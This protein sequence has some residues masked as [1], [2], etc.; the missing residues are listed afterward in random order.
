MTGFGRG[1]FT[2]NYKTFIVEVRAVNHRYNDISIRMPRTFNSFEDKIRE[3]IQNNISRGKVDI[4][5]SYTNIGVSDKRVVLDK[6]LTGEYI[7]VLN[8]VKDEFNISDKIDLSLITRLP[9]IIRIESDEEDQDEIWILLKNALEFAISNLVS[10]RENEG[11]MLKEDVIGR[12][13]NIGKIVNEIEQKASSIIDEYREKLSNRIKDLMKNSPVDESKI[14]MEVA[15]MADKSSIA[16]EIVRLRS[17]LSQ[18]TSTLDSSNPIG[19]KLDFIVQEMN[20]ES[21][22]INSKTGNIEIIRGIIEIKT[23]IEKIREQIQ[24]IE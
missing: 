2:Q 6:Q 1:E 24:N 22:T 20:R 17:H 9:D 12:L 4:Y 19:R 5:I 14:A 21:N 13:E 10:M 16:E 23:E 8:N 15:I 7:N 3:Y 11:E 18:M